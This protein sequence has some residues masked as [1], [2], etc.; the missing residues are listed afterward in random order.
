MKKDTK[1]TTKASAAKKKTDKPVP[2]S[3]AVIPRSL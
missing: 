2:T 3:T 1:K